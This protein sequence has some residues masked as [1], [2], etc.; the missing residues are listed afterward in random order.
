MRQIKLAFLFACKYLGAFAVARRLTRGS[1]KILCYHGF[2]LHDEALFR[3]KLFMSSATFA[4]RMARLSR[5]GMRVLPL[6]EA[7]RSM[8]E[9]RLPPHALAITIDDGFGTTPALAA[10]VLSRHG[11]PST[12]YVTSYYVK[13]NVPIYRLV[14][15]YM[16]WRT[17]ETSITFRRCDWHPDETIELSAE[18]RA[19]L[20]DDLIARGE[21]LDAEQERLD[22]CDEL[23]RMLGVSFQDIVDQRFLHLMT[24]EQLRTLGAQGMDVQLHT[25]RHRFPSDSASLAKREIEDNR[26]SLCEWLPGQR[27]EHFCYPSGLWEPQQHAWLDEIGV[28]SST[29]CLPGLNTASTPRHALRRFLDGENIHPLEFEA[30]VCG[31]SDLVSRRF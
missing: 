12:V 9:G 26:S 17:T 19:A 6:H 25:H 22:I 29:T 10:S 13:H 11:L 18:G 21:A 1:L 8:Y 2:A 15:Q 5:M 24:P 3:P 30:A 23:G 20:A 7:V 4:D 27:F 28:K 31:F 14:V 16:L